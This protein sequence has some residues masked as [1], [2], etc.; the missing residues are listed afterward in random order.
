MT[1]SDAI[2][3]G[4]KITGQGTDWTAEKGRLIF[5]GPSEEFVLKMVEKFS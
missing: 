5:N 4:W 3:Q 1:K 2:K